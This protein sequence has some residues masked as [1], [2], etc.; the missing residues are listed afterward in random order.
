MQDVSW[1]ENPIIN[2]L[3]RSL[4]IYDYFVTVIQMLFGLMG[5]YSLERFDLECFAHTLNIGSHHLVRVLWFDSL[6][7]GLESIPGCH[8]HVGLLAFGF[9]AN[10]EAV[11]ARGW[12]AIDVRSK[13]N[14]DQIFSFKFEGVFFERR[15]VSSGFID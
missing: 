11:G 4:F 3:F 14:L 5:K 10:D 7:C 13:I 1:G 9:S 6:C 15:K 8:E 2:S 12:E